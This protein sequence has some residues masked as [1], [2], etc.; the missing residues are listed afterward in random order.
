VPLPL[1]A[2]LLPVSSGIQA[3][4]RYA[5]AAFPVFIALGEVLRRRAAFITVCAL[6]ALWLLLF[7][8]WFARWAPMVAMPR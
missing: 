3:I 6:C 4:E 8:A 1:L 5:L 2:L 7:T